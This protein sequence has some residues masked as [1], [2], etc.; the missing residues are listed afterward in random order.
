MTTLGNSR[1][2]ALESGPSNLQLVSLVFTL[3]VSLQLRGLIWRVIPRPSFVSRCYVANPVPTQLICTI[4]VLGMIQFLRSL[5]LSPL[6]PPHILRILDPVPLLVVL[7]G[8][9]SVNPNPQ[10][11]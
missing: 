11:G 7:T 1:L 10:R 5:A 2:E 9:A 8:I 3:P 6:V 4:A